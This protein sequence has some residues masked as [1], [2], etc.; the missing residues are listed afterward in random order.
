MKNKLSIQVIEGFLLAFLLVFNVI[1]IFF[2]W[3]E[4]LALVLC[5]IT[6]VLIV[7]L[8]ARYKNKIQKRNRVLTII[9][10]FILWSSILI[11]FVY[12]V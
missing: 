10:S 6:F 1:V 2:N 12:N 5:T 3:F 11:A 4:A 7:L 8:I 9:I